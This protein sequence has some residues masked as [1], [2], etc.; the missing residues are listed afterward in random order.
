MNL[1]GEKDS[2]YTCR[3]VSNYKKWMKG[4]CIL[5]DGVLVHGAMEVIGTMDTTAQGLGYRLYVIREG[6]M[7]LAGTIA[8]SGFFPITMAV[9]AVMLLGAAAGLYIVTCRQYR[10]RIAELTGQK[11]KLLTGWKLWRLKEAAQEIEYELT[12]ENI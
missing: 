2:L 7:P 10:R 12:G 11:Q 6:V 1:F 8:R 4:V 9:M 3:N 5:V